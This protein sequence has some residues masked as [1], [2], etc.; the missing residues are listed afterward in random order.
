MG[1]V[2]IP[3][4]IFVIWSVSICPGIGHLSFFKTNFEYCS[5]LFLTQK[6]ALFHSDFRKKT[7]HIFIKRETW[8]VRKSCITKFR[9]LLQQK[10]LFFLGWVV[11]LGIDRTI[12]GDPLSKSNFIEVGMLSKWFYLVL[13]SV[14]QKTSIVI[15]KESAALLELFS[16]T[17]FASISY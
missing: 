15:N 11:T 2:T 17:S 12:T 7:L 6:S 9:G 4:R 14:F 3:Y 8:S 13:F 5:S 16:W 1:S 10:K